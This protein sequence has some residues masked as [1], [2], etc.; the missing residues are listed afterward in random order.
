L[1]FRHLRFKA[2]A[3][4]IS[5]KVWEDWLKDW[6]ASVRVFH[7]AAALRNRGHLAA[8]LDPLRGKQSRQLSPK[9]PVHWRIGGKHGQKIPSIDVNRCL[10][11]TPGE[12]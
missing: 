6:H 3:L 7:L 11:P 4:D 5:E 1:L 2:D 9:E 10:G 8:T 12:H